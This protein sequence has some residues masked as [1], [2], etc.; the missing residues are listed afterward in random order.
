MDAFDVPLSVVRLAEAAVFASPEPLT[1]NKL[2]PLLPRD[3]DPGLVFSVLERHCA[4][5]GVVLARAGEGW[6][7]WS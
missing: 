3:L 7:R 5:R 1:W 2:Q 6:N 4:A